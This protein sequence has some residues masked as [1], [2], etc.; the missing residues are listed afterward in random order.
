MDPGH[1]N[2][3][4]IIT[5]F[6]SSNSYARSERRKEEGKERNDNDGDGDGEV[7]AMAYDAP[8]DAVHFFCV[9]QLWEYEIN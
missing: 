3:P 6:T 4:I 7:R 1:G 9:R 2:Q 8:Y 5:R